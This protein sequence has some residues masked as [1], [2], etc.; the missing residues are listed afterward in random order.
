MY[1]SRIHLLFPH[2]QVDCTG[3]IGQNV[4]NAIGGF[5]Y[6][7]NEERCGP[8]INLLHTPNKGSMS[9]KSAK[10]HEERK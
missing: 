4:R 7:S 10:L 5:R 2:A 8:R 1:V 6:R 9:V 3:L